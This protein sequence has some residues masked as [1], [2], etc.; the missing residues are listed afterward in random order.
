MT[1]LCVDIHRLHQKP[2]KNYPL[3]LQTSSSNKPICLQAVSDP[4][5]EGEIQDAPNY[6]SFKSDWT[7]DDI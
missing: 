5:V 7:F 3:A 1:S 4:E 2:P 6:T